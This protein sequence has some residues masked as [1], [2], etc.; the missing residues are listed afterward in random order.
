MQKIASVKKLPYLLHR[1]CFSWGENNAKFVVS[2]LL[3][4]SF[5]GVRFHETILSWMQAVSLDKLT[6]LDI[7]GPLTVPDHLYS[8]HAAFHITVSLT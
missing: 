7:A 3:L 1:D 6:V 4:S 8:P 5:F 2:W